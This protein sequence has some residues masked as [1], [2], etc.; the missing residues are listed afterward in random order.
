MIVKSGGG[1]GGAVAPSSIT[2]GT[3]DQILVTNHA[4]TTAIWQSFINM[5]N[6]VGT[7]PAAGFIRIGDDAGLVNVIR[8]IHG[9]SE[10]V[11]IDT[12]PTA[13]STFFGDNGENTVIRGFTLQGIAN[14]ANA[15]F[16][17]AN[18]TTLFA[19]AADLGGGVGVLSIPSATT[20]P[21]TN[22]GGIIVYTSVGA[23]ALSLRAR[24]SQGVVWELAPV[25]QGAVSTQSRLYPEIEGVRTG[26]GVIWTGPA[27]PSG[28]SYSVTVQI[29]ARS[30][31]AGGGAVGDTRTF[32][33]TYVWT[34]KAGVLTLEGS[35]HA[36]G[37]NG[38]GTAALAALSTSGGVSG[39]SPTISVAKNTAT[40][41]IDWTIFGNAGQN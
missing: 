21:T 35:N 26:D 22:P 16:T 8:G 12:N 5:K 37:A 40:S 14:A 3:A 18:G 2:P 41:T 11:I 29:N 27:I 17:T 32:L 7:V 15:W 38:I 20:D 13:G 1:G 33:D 23:P 19:A 24:T 39:T 30:T 6:S 31:T 4:G 34:N 28:H 36:A 25:G 9:G 10:Y